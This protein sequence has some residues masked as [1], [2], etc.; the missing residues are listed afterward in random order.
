LQQRSWISK[1]YATI[2][3]IRPEKSHIQDWIALLSAIALHKWF[4]KFIADNEAVSVTALAFWRDLTTFICLLFLGLTTI[5]AKL[6]IK[7]SDWRD[8]AGMGASLGASVLL[9]PFQFY[10]SQ[11]WPI[12]PTSWL[13]FTGLIGLS[14]L[15]AE[16][17][18]PVCRRDRKITGQYRQYFA[19]VGDCFG[20]L[21]CVPSAW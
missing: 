8:M 2:G 18:F 6:R 20:G 5:P 3:L 10:V 11:P 1:F 21:L 4:V 16:C 17:L 9:L 14:T 15:N 7:R 12:Q 13:W 19:D